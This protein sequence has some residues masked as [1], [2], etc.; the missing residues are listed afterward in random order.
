MS[1]TTAP[2]GGATPAAPLSVQLFSVR[3]QLADDQ[4]AALSRLAEIGFRHVEPFGLGSPQQ[5]AD[6]RMA[7]VRRLRRSLDAAGLGVSTVHA[8]LPADLSQLAAECAAL[9][10]DTVLVPHPHLVPGF[11]EDAFAD[12]AR[13]DAFAGTLAEAAHELAGH[14]LRLGYHN[15]WFEWTPLPDGT[16]AWDRFWERAGDALVAEVDV[17]WAVTA[18]ADPAHVLTRLGDRVVALHL[19]DGPARR[20]IPQTPIGTGEVDLTAVLRGAPHSIRWHVAEIDTTDM[21]VY[22]LLE[23]NARTLVGRGL[24]RWAR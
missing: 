15:H 19:K 23:R 13:L 16:P 8:G 22:A 9:G 7:H 12:P 17:Y 21:D 1:T 10:A 20:D 6:E 14:G 11:G 24:S 18:G 3:A 4:D 2:S 5:P